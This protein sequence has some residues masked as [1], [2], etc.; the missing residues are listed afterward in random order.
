[1]EWKFWVIY[2]KPV[3]FSHVLWIALH[4]HIKSQLNQLH[5]AQL[6]A[7]ITISSS[8]IECIDWDELLHRSTRKQFLRRNLITKSNTFL[9]RRKLHVRLWGWYRMYTPIIC[10]IANKIEQE[11]VTIFHLPAEQQNLSRAHIV[12]YM[13]RS[14]ET[15]IVCTDFLGAWPTRECEWPRCW[16]N[17]LC[18]RIKHI[19]PQLINYVQRRC[20]FFAI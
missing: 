16:R 6:K 3:T 13:S 10:I 15:Q 8:L 20:Q 18:A 9:L 19:L 1:M 2:S 12:F 11:I 17:L 7:E 5:V 4:T 14:R